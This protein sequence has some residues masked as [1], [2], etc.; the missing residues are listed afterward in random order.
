MLRQAS[1]L[2]PG[3]GLCQV[4]RQAHFRSKIYFYEAAPI[5]GRS[6]DSLAGRAFGRL[7]QNLFTGF[8]TDR[9]NNFCGLGPGWDSRMSV[10]STTITRRGRQICFART[11]S[12]SWQ[13]LPT[14]FVAPALIRI[15]D[16][17]GYPCESKRRASADIMAVQGISRR[18]FT[19]ETFCGPYALVAR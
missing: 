16:D 14:L 8:F 6:L 2:S 3:H 17:S 18:R 9:V 1:T 5:L 13:K 10:A 4:F 11:A 19:T 15:P 7:D 12:R